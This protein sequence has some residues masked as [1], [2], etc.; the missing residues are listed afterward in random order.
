MPL[1]GFV[2]ASVLAT[3][4]TVS[5]GRYRYRVGATRASELGLRE[6]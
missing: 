1:T 6:P 4:L 3:L 5:L 2:C